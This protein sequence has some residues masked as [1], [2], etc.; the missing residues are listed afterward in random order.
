MVREFVMGWEPRQAFTL[1]MIDF[2]VDFTHKLCAALMFHPLRD[3]G[4]GS[5]LSLVI[6]ILCVKHPN[7][8]G[9]SEKL[10]VLWDK[11]LCDSNILVTYRKPRPEWLP[12]HALVLQVSSF[13]SCLY[14]FPLMIT[15][16][17]GGRLIFETTLYKV[18]YF[19]LYMY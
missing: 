17:V 7:L 15:R 10:D 13:M 6:G 8:F 3:A 14:T 1:A 19:S 4:V 2:N 9:K 16:Q 18:S 5:P 11:G 12:Q